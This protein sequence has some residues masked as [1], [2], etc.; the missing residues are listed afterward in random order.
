MRVKD[1]KISYICICDQETG[2]RIYEGE[3]DKL[4]IELLNKK[5]VYQKNCYCE[6]K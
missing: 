5:V 6:I 2:Q 1:L 3:F 4:P